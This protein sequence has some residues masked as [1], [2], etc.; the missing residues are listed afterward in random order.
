MYCSYFWNINVNANPPPQK[1]IRD[2]C[3]LIFLLPSCG[4]RYTL[5]GDYRTALIGLVSTV[6]LR[7]GAVGA[8]DSRSDPLRR[9]WPLWDVGLPEGRLQNSS[10]DQLSRWIVRLFTHAHTFAINRCTFTQ[11]RQ[12]DWSET[13][14]SMVIL[15]QSDLFFYLCSTCI[16]RK[17]I[18][19]VWLLNP[20]WV[21]GKQYIFKDCVCKHPFLRP[22]L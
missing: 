15:S 4:H 19:T 10:T 22:W 1:K 13:L 6:G 12:V 14:K 11:P 16:L 17:Y 5:H 2:T 9:H 7:S 21:T 20:S 3:H 8:D 18:Y